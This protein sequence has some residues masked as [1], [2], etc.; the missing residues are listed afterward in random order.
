MYV[1]LFF[2]FVFYMLFLNNNI[3]LKELYV[4]LCL[5]L[6][7]VVGKRWGKERDKNKL[8]SR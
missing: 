4:Y 8:N 1:C 2:C 3:K 6:C 5:M 7:L